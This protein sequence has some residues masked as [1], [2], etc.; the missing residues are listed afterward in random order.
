MLALAIFSA[1]A[2]RDR[3][4]DQFTG[5]ATAPRRRRSAASA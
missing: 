1:S 5:P 3:V 2:A 4:A